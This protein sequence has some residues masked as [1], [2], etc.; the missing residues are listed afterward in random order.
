MLETIKIRRGGIGWVIR[1]Y[2]GSKNFVKKYFV[3]LVVQT[4]SAA[5]L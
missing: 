3:L 1:I 4:L 2:F 5:L